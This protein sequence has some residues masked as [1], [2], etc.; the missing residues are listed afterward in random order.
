MSDLARRRADL[1]ATPKLGVVVNP[2]SGRNRSG[3]QALDALLA[4]QPQIAV[5]RPASPDRTAASLAALAAQGVNVL[6]IC[7]GDGTVQQVLNVILEPGSPFPALPLLAV[8]PGGTTNMIAHDVNVA[9]RPVAVLENLL[10]SLANGLPD[11]A[12]VQR[13]VMSLTGGAASAPSYGLFFGA[14]GIYE[15]TM[16]NRASVDRLGV[17]DG[18]GP[19][20]RIAAILFKAATGRDPFAPTPMRITI[21]GRPYGEKATVVALAS[22]MNNLSMGL[23]PFWS[24]G[25]GSIRLTL[26][27]KASRSILRAVWLAL[28]SRPH[29]FLTPENGYDSLNA[30]RVELAFDGGCVLDGESFHASVDSPIVLKS[31]GILRFLRG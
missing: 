11:G 13:P 3:T 14:A 25:D 27:F 17:R 12:I 8:L 22:T 28:R 2:N 5:E 23:K 9:N 6:A 20:L 26:V 16:Q 18:L 30:D 15:A 24:E 31:A 1:P 29:P 19:A 21:D 4:R 10:R 7:G